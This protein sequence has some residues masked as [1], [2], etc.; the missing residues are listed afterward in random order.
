MDSDVPVHFQ[1][2]R[3]RVAEKEVAEAHSQWR[4]PEMK[5]RM[6]MQ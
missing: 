1:E 4:N 3:C 6:D 2:K 5:Y